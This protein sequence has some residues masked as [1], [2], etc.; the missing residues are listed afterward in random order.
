[1]EQVDS[2]RTLL[3]M[4]AEIPDPR[5]RQGRRYPIQGLLAALI[6]AALNGQA[7]LRGNST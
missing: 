1:M 6:L 5:G 2:G 4:L 7:S 3:E